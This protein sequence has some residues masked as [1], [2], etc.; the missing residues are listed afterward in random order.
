MDFRNFR[1]YVDGRTIKLLYFQ[2]L[3]ARQKK[4]GFLRKHKLKVWFINYGGK[5]VSRKFFL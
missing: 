3:I 5:G 4:A 2:V 1:N